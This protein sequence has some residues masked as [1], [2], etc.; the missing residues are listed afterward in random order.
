MTRKNLDTQRVS[1]SP[2]CVLVSIRRYAQTI[3]PVSPV[4]CTLCSGSELRDVF[5]KVRETC[6][7]SDLL[8]FSW[9]L[10][11]FVQDGLNEG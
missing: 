7:L 4:V 1:F 9:F 5:L 6:V 3:D 11:R 8:L 10:P 2:P